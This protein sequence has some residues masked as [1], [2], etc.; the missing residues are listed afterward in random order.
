VAE[1]KQHTLDLLSAWQRQGAASAGHAI[2]DADG[3]TMYGDARQLD[4]W[5]EQEGS[6]GLQRACDNSA[7]RLKAWTVMPWLRAPACGWITWRV[8]YWGFAEQTF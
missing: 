7:L 8:W 1:S 4:A 2:L 3:V 5:R 6:N